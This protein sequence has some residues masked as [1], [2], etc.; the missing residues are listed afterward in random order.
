[1]TR[2]ARIES[3][4]VAELLDTD[5]DIASL[6]PLE[7]VWVSA[8]PDVEQRWTFDGKTFAAPV[9]PAFDLQGAVVGAVQSRLDTFARTRDYD[10]ILSA[11]TYSSSTVAKF[12][13]EGAYCVQARDTH[14]S[15]CYQ[16]MADV[17]AGRRAVPTV[18]DVL[19]LMPALV[20]P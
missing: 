10:G 11:C 18:G 3:G 12:A 6:F 5:A 8:T 13:A 9:P 2:Y 20:W 17:Q 15:S 7:L 16:L 4:V 14:W 19:A 1:M